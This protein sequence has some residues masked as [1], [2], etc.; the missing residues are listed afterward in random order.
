MNAAKAERSEGHA[1]REQIVFENFE[2]IRDVCSRLPARTALWW[3]AEQNAWQYMKEGPLYD[4]A[5]RRG[6]VVQ[7][8]EALK[9]RRRGK[10]LVAI[11][12]HGGVLYQFV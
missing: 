1:E 3:D 11:V 7:L 5:K 6:T 8:D 2:W 4:D 9:Q 12:A 10:R